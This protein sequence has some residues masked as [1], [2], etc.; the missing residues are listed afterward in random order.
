MSLRDKIQANAQ[1]VINDLGKLAS[2][3]GDNFGYNRESVEFI[4]GYIERCKQ[5]GVTPEQ[6]EGLVQ[7]L[8]SFLGE[9]IVHVYGGEWREYE[10]QPGIFFE[11]GSGAFPFSK[12]RMQF[13]NGLQDSVLGFYDVQEKFCKGE[14]EFDDDDGDGVKILE[15][16]E[17]RRTDPDGHRIK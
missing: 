11:N 3:L 14:I 7:M 10:G 8:G 17:P 2:D 16:G 6:T 5:R 9:C 4:E 13:K 15:I 1:M 12:V